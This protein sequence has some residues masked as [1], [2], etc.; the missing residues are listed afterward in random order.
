MVKYYQLNKE[1]VCT[2]FFSGRFISVLVCLALLPS[3]LL[4]ASYITEEYY[5]TFDFSHS[6]QGAYRN[7]TGKHIRLRATCTEYH[8]DHPDTN[9]FVFLH[10]K[11]LLGYK[12]IG[13]PAVFPKN[14]TG[15]HHW[16]NVDAG[17]YGFFFRKIVL[18]DDRSRLVSD[19]VYMYGYNPTPG[20][21]NPVFP[22]TND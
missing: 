2:K 6:V 9:Y 14:G 8:H 22:M 13:D 4:A 7:Y 17:K 10:K 3:L 18:G 1:S 21:G 20:G 16:L 15:V 19:D 12:V 5:S 11:T